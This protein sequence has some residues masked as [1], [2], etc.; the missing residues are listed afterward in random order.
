MDLIADA[1]YWI[2]SALILLA[3]ATALGLL[4]APARLQ[5][6]ARVLDSWHSL[7]PA[8][9]PL[10]KPRYTERRIYRHHRLAG[11][12]IVAGA[13]YTLLRLAGID[14][15]ATLALLPAHWDEG[16]RALLAANVYWFLLLANLAALGVGLAVYFRPSLLKHLEARSNHWLST[17][18]AMK[19]LDTYH[20]ELNVALWRHP[21]LTGAFLLI[22]SVYVWA[23]LIAYRH[24]IL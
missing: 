4:A 8:L 10:D 16:L 2:A 20:T 3:L 23:V 1:L 9:G 24:G 15:H 21:R 14:T 11:A 22:G 17:R 12:L 19:P 6:L 13:G 18:Q 7:R 5:S